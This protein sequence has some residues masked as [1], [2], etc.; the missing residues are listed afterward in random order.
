MFIFLLLL[1]FVFSCLYS[2]FETWNSFDFP[3]MLLLVVSY[4]HH[5]LLS[6]KNYYFFFHH[7]L[8]L[9]P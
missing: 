9:V 1:L 2:Y 3:S 6:L 7:Y 5:G 8:V 4:F